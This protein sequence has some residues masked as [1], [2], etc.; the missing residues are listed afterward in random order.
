MLP[1]LFRGEPASQ[2]AGFGGQPAAGSYFRVV[3]PLL[4]GALHRLRERCA[5]HG[6]AAVY[7]FPIHNP[8]IASSLDKATAISHFL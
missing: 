3:E 5:L 2:L 8:I 7:R 6:F 4:H 1:A